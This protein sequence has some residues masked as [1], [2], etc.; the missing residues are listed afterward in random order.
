MNS[1]QRRQLLNLGLFSLVVVLL[2]VVFSLDEEPP[3]GTTALLGLEGA[4]IDQLRI[5]RQGQP[6]IELQRS[7]DEWR[8]LE[9]IAHPVSPFRIESLLRIAA[10]PTWGQIPVAEANLADYG[11]K[12]AEVALTINRHTVLYFGAQTALDHRRYVRLDDTI[13]IVPDT[14]YY[15]LLGEP[16]GYLAHRLLAVD[17]RIEGIEGE[18]FELGL[19]DGT[20]QL[21]GDA[22]L[23]SA[24]R[25]QE[26]LDAWLHAGVVRIRPYDGRSGESVLLWLAGEDEPLR[27]L[28]IG[29][30]E[31]T[32]LA[33]VD[34][35]IQYHLSQTSA[36]MMFAQ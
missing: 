21:N 24:D 23:G 12:Q 27:F 22:P 11:L 28:K 30:G 9:P 14:L 29:E 18:G 7:G 19:S 13:H 25:I 10:L 6:T 2:L 4:A 3:P 31:E 16:V 15:H 1:V 20:W 5:E 26:I 36:Q 17:A 32:I 34:L 8:M 33:R 35:G